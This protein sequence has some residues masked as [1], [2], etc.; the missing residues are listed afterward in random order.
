MGEGFLTQPHFVH[1]LIKNKIKSM[2]SPKILIEL[3]KWQWCG[4][5]F[6]IRYAKGKVGFIFF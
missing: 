3:F 4:G 2:L 1:Q 5:G 6:K